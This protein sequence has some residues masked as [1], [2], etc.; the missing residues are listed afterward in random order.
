MWSPSNLRRFSHLRNNCV[1]EPQSH[2]GS[3]SLLAPR[4]QGVGGP[5]HAS[6][7]GALPSQEQPRRTRPAAPRTVFRVSGG[8][9]RSLW[10]PSF[11]N[12]QRGQTTSPTDHDLR[13][14]HL[15][16]A[17]IPGYI[18]ALCGQSLHFWPDPS[19]TSSS[20]RHCFTRS[21]TTSRRGRHPSKARFCP[22]KRTP[23]RANCWCSCKAFR[24][25]AALSSTRSEIGSN[26]TT[27]HENG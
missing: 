2:S 1:E 11:K 14:Q 20:D 17:L 23:W 12:S 19:A 4:R 5:S 24:T 13:A 15:L 27:H 25:A 21:P 16:D 8:A 10:S 7:V 22:L 18:R 6:Q 3:P 9:R 26:N